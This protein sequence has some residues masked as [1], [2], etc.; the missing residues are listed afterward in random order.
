MSN[1][2]PIVMDLSGRSR[3]PEGPR[4]S[5]AP[6]SVMSRRAE[7]SLET[8]TRILDSAEELFSKRGGDGVTRPDIAHLAD[9]DTALLHYYFDSKRGIFEAVLERRA[10]ILEYEIGE[11]LSRYERRNPSV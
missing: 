10:A 8:R 3:D 9:V 2:V 6:V 7:K 11:S 4:E 5:A 1:P